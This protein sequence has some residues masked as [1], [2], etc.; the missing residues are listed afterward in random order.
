M[1]S[2]FTDRLED[3]RNRLNDIQ[4]SATALSE[5]LTFSA[6]ESDVFTGAAN[7]IT[8]DIE[9]TVDKLRE[10]INELASA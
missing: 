9:G 3:I 6:Y 7:L 10:L 2:N 8:D 1:I 4:S 5:A